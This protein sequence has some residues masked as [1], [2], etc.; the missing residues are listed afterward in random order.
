[1]KYFLALCT[2][3]ALFGCTRTETKYETQTHFVTMDDEWLKDCVVVPPPE[4]VAYEAAP[5]GVRAA[6]WSKV[7]VR[8]LLENSL[9]NKGTGKARAFNETAKQ[10]NLLLIQ[11]K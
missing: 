4:K 2:V 9:C 3:L 8:Q 7:Y 10:K 5:E 6:M 11:N 1:M